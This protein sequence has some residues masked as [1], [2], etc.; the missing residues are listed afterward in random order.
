MPKKT[1]TL[2]DVDQDVYV[3]CFTVGPEDVGG[4]AAGYRIVKR[5]VYGGLRDGVDVV[6]VDNGQLRFVV[7]PTRGMGI[8]RAKMADMPLGW[9]SP[10]KGPVHPAFVHLNEASGLGWL[11]GFDELVCRCGLESNG[12]PEFH[13]DGRLRYSLHGKIANCPAQ[14]LEVSID[15][16]TGLIAV[17][18]VVDEA[19]LF[20]NKLRMTSTITTR[21]GQPSFT[22]TD[23]VTNISA[24]PGELEL[25]YHI[26]VGTPLL[27]P[28]AKLVA[29]FH[30]MAPHNDVAV[31][32]LPD[33]DTYGPETPGAPEACF[34]YDL[35]ADPEGQ[36]QVLL[37]NAA[38]TRGLS[39]SF[40]K[41]QLPYFIQWKNRQAVIDGYVTGMEPATNFPNNKS[42]EKTKG[43][44]VVLPPGGSRTFQVTLQAHPTPETVAAAKAQVE[45][46]QENVPREILPK[47][48]PDW[49][50][51]A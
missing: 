39:V 6:E 48:N 8:W 4:P 22:I 26:N 7:V 50:R 36:T 49:S 46:L 35:A 31:G 51:G 19:R 29:A 15:G 27:E 24:E 37:H 33:W 20:G 47:P 40:N 13:E 11:D 9:Q 17:L 38:G 12:A 2:T 32:N 3:E 1:W 41:R 34:F 30:K 44:V 21:V 23:V 45:K 14:K 10:V 25:L 18:G 5:R 28:G 42:F 16:D 43:R